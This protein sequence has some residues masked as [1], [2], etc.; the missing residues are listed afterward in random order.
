MP[1][2]AKTEESTDQDAWA[3]YNKD[4]APEWAAGDHGPNE[5]TRDLVTISLKGG[6]G[7]QAWIVLHA[8]GVGEALDVL[9]DPEWEELVG[10]VAK[11][12]TE[13]Q[14]AHG[15]SS[16]PA[17]FAQKP[18]GGSGWGNRGSSNSSQK[19]PSAKG[20]V[21]WNS[22]ERAYGCQHGEAVKRE[23]ESAK[24][25]WVGY[26]CPE[27]DRDEQCKPKFKN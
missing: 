2:K 8:N 7:T 16:K 17:G 11:R 22:D 1:T 6:S 19:R 25:P 24:G 12:G 20:E 5:S 27:S 18:S 26:F 3:D 23:G 9:N 14:E 10:L 4:A 13:L 15:G 21:S